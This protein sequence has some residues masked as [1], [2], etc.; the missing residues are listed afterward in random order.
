MLSL[1][2]TAC[3]RSRESIAPNR[4]FSLSSEWRSASE[5][6]I[7]RARCHD[8]VM[9]P[10]DMEAWLE[11]VSSLGPK[12]SVTFN[13]IRLKDENA[14]LA[15]VLREMFIL[16]D[17]A[18]D[19]VTPQPR[20]REAAGC[21]KALCVARRMFDGDLGV[22][23]LYMGYAYGHNGSQYAFE[24]SQAFT[25]DELDTVLEAL[26]D[27][28][29]G[30][31]PLATM[32]RAR[33]VQDGVSSG[34]AG[35][36]T[37]ANA[38]MSFFDRWSAQTQE[39]RR[40]TVFH[41]LGHNMAR[42]TALEGIWPDD[43]TATSQYARTNIAENI[44]EA[45]VAYRYNPRPLESDSPEKYAILKSVVFD[46]L[47]YSS[48]STCDSSRSYHGVSRR[49]EFDPTDAAAQANALRATER[50]CQREIMA[51]FMGS[52]LQDI[53]LAGCGIAAVSDRDYVRAI[54]GS[55]LPTSWR[56]GIAMRTYT[57]ASVPDFSLIRPLGSTNITALARRALSSVRHRYQSAILEVDQRGRANYGTAEST[58]ENVESFCARQMEFMYQALEA[59][60]PDLK[61]A[62]ALT[63]F[64]AERELAS[65]A[66]ARCVAMHRRAGF[67]RLAPL[68]AD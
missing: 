67:D 61:R 59:Q 1:V 60:Y 28:P 13:G 30:T 32:K 43:G 23:L 29:A 50:T 21:D 41:E 45:I 54:N 10:A 63:F 16:K 35:D 57:A 3:G 5:R 4:S 44:A 7:A 11:R 64:R 15:M 66:A 8:Q 68:K 40:Y 27:Y 51:Y 34:L 20:Y 14:V 24:G 52:D 33:R 31:W 37:R 48:E 9:A 22:K 2:A 26:G 56:A 46:G 19:A 55:G 39:G 47:E 18:N 25:D 17:S 38:T 53:D 58:L 65:A 62:D 36:E 42:R 12:T 49:V 6:D